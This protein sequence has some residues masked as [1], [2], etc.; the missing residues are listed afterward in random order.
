MLGN[1]LFCLFVLLQFCILSLPSPCACVCALETFISKP[2]RGKGVMGGHRN[3][4]EQLHSLPR[5]SRNRRRRRHC[6]RRRH[7]PNANDPIFDT[8]FTIAKEVVV[9]TAGSARNLVN[10]PRTRV[11]NAP[12]WRARARA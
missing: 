9:N 7:A 8:T 12:K 2:V 10:W 4:Y 11:G 3:I 5:Q 1:R 6:C